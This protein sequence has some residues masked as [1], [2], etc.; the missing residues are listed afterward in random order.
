MFEQAS[1]ESRKVDKDTQQDPGL[2]RVTRVQKNLQV[3]GYEGRTRLLEKLANTK[4]CLRR[5]IGTKEQV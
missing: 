5:H 4:R 1:R 3:R 2:K